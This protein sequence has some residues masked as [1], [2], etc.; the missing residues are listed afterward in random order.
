MGVSGT[1][2]MEPAIQIGTAT[3]VR[4]TLRHGKNEPSKKIKKYPMAVK[5]AAEANKI[6][7]IDVSLLQIQ[8]K[9]VL[10]VSTTEFYFI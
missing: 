7:R 10:T 8:A 6:P 2:H 4:A 3:A 9:L 5:M 1:K